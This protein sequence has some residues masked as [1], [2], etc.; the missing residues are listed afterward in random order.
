L[1]QKLLG[2]VQVDFFD[3][4][5]HLKPLSEH[6]GKIPVIVKNQGTSYLNAKFD[7][8]SISMII[9]VEFRAKQD[10]VRRYM[11]TDEFQANYFF[12]KID[13]D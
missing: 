10:T 8:T 3:L 12:I 13:L 6:S 4:I 7:C 9:V 2:I 11:P 5:F 1:T